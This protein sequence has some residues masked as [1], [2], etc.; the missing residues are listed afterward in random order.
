MTKPFVYHE[1]LGREVL[2]DFFGEKV[3]PDGYELHG[4][5]TCRPPAP[6]HYAFPEQE[7]HSTGFNWATVPKRNAEFA[8]SLGWGTK[9]P[10][11]L[12]VL[13]IKKKDP[14]GLEFAKGVG[15]WQKQHHRPADGILGPKTWDLMQRLHPEVFGQAGAKR[16]A[17]E[18]PAHAGAMQDALR[19]SSGALTIRHPQIMGAARVPGQ[20]NS[21]MDSEFRIFNDMVWD[22]DKGELIWDPHQASELPMTDFEIGVRFGAG[23]LFGLGETIFFSNPLLVP[24]MAIYG[25]YDVSKRMWEAYDEYGDNMDGFL[26]ALNQVNPIYGVA[27][28]VIDSSNAWERGEYFAS[29]RGGFHATFQTVTMIV[30]AAKLGSQFRS[31]PIWGKSPSGPR[32]PAAPKR[33]PAGPRPPKRSPAGPKPPKKNTAGPPPPKQLP[34]G[35]KPPKQ[36]P[37]VAKSTVVARVQEM[38]RNGKAIAADATSKVAKTLKRF[39]NPKDPTGKQAK[40]IAKELNEKK[41]R[42]E[43]LDYM[44]KEESSGRTKPHR[45]DP[46][47]QKIWEYEDGTVVRYKPNGDMHSGGKP[48]YSVEVLKEGRTMSKKDKHIAF[49]VDGEGRAVPA[50]QKSTK[51]HSHDPGKG[52]PYPEGT[53]EHAQYVQEMMKAGHKHL[54]P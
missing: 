34:A 5:N 41:T 1:P 15:A 24:F 37:R 23:V 6:T 31:G 36:L 2:S 43:F 32:L 42:K 50:N 44:A 54:Q 33:L 51:P 40:R 9:R 14:N 53:I 45:T 35:P 25:V 29:G 48:T 3:C 39:R 4:V 28:L 27:V 13:G 12:T 47:G 49:K 52:N 18:F 19:P 22:W 10:Q 21:Q 30:S 38:I 11:I 26:M 20:L 46:N 17:F 7:I 8:R 16:P